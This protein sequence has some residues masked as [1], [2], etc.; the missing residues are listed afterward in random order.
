MLC[1]KCFFALLLLFFYPAAYSAEQNN[2]HDNG[3]PLWQLDF[4]AL[5]DVAP[6]E[7][8]AYLQSIGIEFGIDSDEIVLEIKNGKLTLNTSERSVVFF[9][10]RLDDK[11]AVPARLAEIDWGVNRFAAEAN[12]EEGNNRVAIA[13]MFVLGTET[14]SS[15]LPFG[16]NAAPYF[17]APFIGEKEKLNKLYKGKLY[18]EAG[19]YICVANKKGEVITRFNIG[20]I[21]RDEFGRHYKKQG[22][23]PVTAIGIQMNTNDTHG[24]A[25]A[26]IRSIRLYGKN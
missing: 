4:S 25:S 16:I 26:F 22:T 15:G 14:F 18:Q 6:E 21:F 10:I 19:R 17:L 11:E 2:E 7:T 12:W 13:T 8:I 3:K 24:G 1:N 23:P 5:A 9:G 20:R